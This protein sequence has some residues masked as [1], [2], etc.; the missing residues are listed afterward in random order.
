M[1]TDQIVQLADPSNLASPEMNL[2]AILR[3]KVIPDFL[4][5][6]LGVSWRRKYMSQ[7]ISSGVPTY[8]M[9]ANLESIFDAR[10]DGATE[11]LP[12][13][14][15]HT[16]RIFAA[17]ASATPR[18][19]TGWWLELS[20]STGL[21]VLH[22]DASPDSNYV[23]RIAYLWGYQFQDDSTAVQLNTLMPEKVQWSLVAG[24]KRELMLDRFGQQD[25][26]FVVA[27]KEYETSKAK[28]LL[29]REEG[30][31]GATIKTII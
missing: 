17:M 30:P 25:A 12:Y 4:S 5:S 14:G 23:L 20:S 13:V 3:F 2:N 22:L 26:R 29:Y 15:E 28:A 18:K 1:T 21:R 6:V 11:P 27:D 31:G 24:L 19:P 7:N 8:D 9:P 10:L 16:H